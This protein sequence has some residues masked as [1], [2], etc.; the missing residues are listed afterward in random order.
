[1]ILKI[2][3][4]LWEKIYS[5]ISRDSNFMEHYSET[6]D[7]SLY[8]YGVLVKRDIDGRVS[9]VILPDN[10]DLTLFLLKWS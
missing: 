1:M 10:E 8:K 9:Y 3:D 4:P 7:Q 6:W 5:K 2:N